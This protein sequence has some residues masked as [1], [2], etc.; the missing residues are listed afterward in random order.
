MLPYKNLIHLDRKAATPIYLQLTNE[1]VP[2]ILELDVVRQASLHHVEA[3]VVA[4]LQLCD[5]LAAGAGVHS[6]DGR[7]ALLRWLG[8]EQ[9]KKD[10]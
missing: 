8:L 2:L 1:L 9:E 7:Q 4:G 10:P 3:V 6:L 5:S